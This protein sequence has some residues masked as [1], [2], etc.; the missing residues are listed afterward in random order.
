MRAADFSAMGGFDESYGTYLNDWDAWLRCLKPGGRLVMPWQPTPMDGRTLV[1]RRVPAGF[2]AALH[3]FVS[4]VGCI[5][6]GTGDIRVRGIPGRPLAETRS[7]WLVSDRPAD[8][9]A[10]AIYPDVWFSADPI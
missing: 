6:A 4:F 5:G 7:V 10:T 2:A 9:S 8:E 1:V 3:G